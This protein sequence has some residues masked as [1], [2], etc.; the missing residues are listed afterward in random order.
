MDHADA[1][2][3]VEFVCKLVIR[4]KTLFYTINL[5]VPT[6]LISFL[7]IFVF[8]LPTDAGEKMTLSISILLALVVFLLLISKI[9]P[10]TSIVIPLIA[11]YL[12]FTFI[13]NIITIFQTVVI[14]NWNYRTPRTHNMPMWVR[15]LCIDILPRILCM[16]RPKKY[17][18]EYHMDEQNSKNNY[19]SYIQA[20]RALSIAT[21]AMN[22]A[23]KIELNKRFIRKHPYSNLQSGSKYINDT[24][25][26]TQA[27]MNRTMLHRNRHDGEEDN[28]NDN[29]H[30]DDYKLSKEA[31]EAADHLRYVANHMRTASQYEAVRDDWKYIASVID[32]LQL[33]VF[34]AVTSAGTFSILFNAPYIFQFVDQQAILNAWIEK[35][36][37]F[38]AQKDEAVF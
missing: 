30:V 2:D 16:E 14:I 6:V 36:F 37:T 26:H 15:K 34:F 1:H 22:V 35:Y 29:G 31:Y 25:K 7:S 8:Y 5:I 3:R 11:K 27:R 33:Y 4:R 24:T 13:M 18:K 17:E 23:Q 20:A 32:R 12:L 38:F 19:A 10:P 21:P 28:F 9:L